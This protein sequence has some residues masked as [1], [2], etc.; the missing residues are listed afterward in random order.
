VGVLEDRIVDFAL[1]LD[2][3]DLSPDVVHQAKRR[4]VD[5]VGG[6]LAACKTPPMQVVQRMSVPIELP[7]SARI[8]GSL[9]RTTPELAAFIN[10]SMLRYLEIN[11]TYGSPGGTHPSDYIGGLVA[12]AEATGASGAE[13]IAAITVSYEIQCRVVDAV[14]F[15][16][17][18]WDQAVVPGLM[19]CSVAAGRLLNLSREQMHSVLALAI[20]PNLATFQSRSGGAISTWKACAAANGARQCLFAANLAAEGMVGPFHPFDG[21][22][23]L[24]KMTMGKPYEIGPFAGKDDGIAFGITESFIK[25]YPVR[26]S[27]QLPVATAVALHKQL[28]PQEIE[29]VRIETYRHA[30]HG[31]SLPEFWAPKTRETSDHSIPASVAIALVD[32]EI[33]PDSYERQRY[34]APDIS[35]L[36]GRMTVDICEDFDKV[37]PRVAAAG[38]RNCR[39]TATLKD[40]S[41]R[42]AHLAWSSDDLK[43]GP[44]DA[45][46]DAKVARLTRDVVP[47]DRLDRMLD[48]LWNLDT[49][50]DVARTVDELG[51]DP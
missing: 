11:D 26:Y 28:N 23:G 7:Y 51:I 9:E 14:P 16:S 32:G 21:T 42:Q 17:V 37:A 10:S 29:S 2:F 44:S 8:W 45:D 49:S 5:T 12:L 39:I 34:L 25:I 50:P 48:A 3:E 4:V 35:K 46:I 13:L 38:V 19:G 30:Y 36:M 1:S 27:C 47:P 18:G 33:T 40:G 6:A 20:I 31:A 43:R 24:W 15:S 41:T 22:F